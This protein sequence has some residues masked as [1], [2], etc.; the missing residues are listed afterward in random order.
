MADQRLTY[1]ISL[2]NNQAD[3][4]ESLLEKLKQAEALTHL[5]TGNDLADSGEEITIN[6][7]GA[8]HSFISAAVDSCEALTQ[9]LLSVRGDFFRKSLE[10]GK[11]KRCNFTLSDDEVISLAETIKQ[12]LCLQKKEQG[13]FSEI[14]EALNTIVG[15]GY[16]TTMS[17]NNSHNELQHC[18]YEEYLAVFLQTRDTLGLSNVTA[19]IIANCVASMID[20]AI[21]NFASSGQQYFNVFR[22]A[23]LTFLGELH[24]N[25]EKISK[26]LGIVTLR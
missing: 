9:E 7:I 18:F 21:T 10:H 16:A 5:A 14:R 1:F 8:L 2:I 3:K 17:S 26:I 15:L 19:E 13:A 20:I 11:T 25:N 4:H 12:Q 6:Y 22:N 24:Q 23:L